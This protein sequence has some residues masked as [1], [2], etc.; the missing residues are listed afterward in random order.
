ILQPTASPDDTE[1]KQYGT[2]PYRIIDGRVVYL[3]I[4]SRGSAN[5]V[6]PKGSPIKGLTPRETAA[7]ET[8]E[9]AGVRGEIADEPAGYYM[10]PRNDDPT[11]L[12]KIELFPLHVTEQL[13]DWPEEPQ[14][15]RHWVLLPQV[16]RL[17]ASK[18][19]ARVAAELD[20][21]LTA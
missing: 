15:F 7:Q 2:I 5:W 19:A 1:G 18:Q 9:E 13:P 17:M 16:R 11:R 10:H 20:R 8:F 6:F 14:R 3:M 21:R 4:T 12:V